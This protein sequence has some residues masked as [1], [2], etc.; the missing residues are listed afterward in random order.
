MGVPQQFPHMPQAGS[1][2]SGWKKLDPTVK[3]LSNS[4]LPIACIQPPS[5][6][7]GLFS[8]PH[9]PVSML[10]LPSS[11]CNFLFSAELCFLVLPLHHPRFAHAE[12][13]LLRPEFSAR[14]WPAALTSYH[15]WPLQLLLVL[16][17]VPES[18]LNF[19]AGK[20]ELR[21]Q[22]AGAAVRHTCSSSEDLSQR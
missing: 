13:S 1:A 3:Q 11:L 21:E 9:H 14:F 17:L 20:A 22:T 15:P 10:H 4:P 2:P 19:C 18:N 6:W 12:H 16:I 8:T 5:R 7:S